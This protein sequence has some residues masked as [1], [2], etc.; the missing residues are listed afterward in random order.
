MQADNEDE[1]LMAIEAIKDRD[2]RAF[3]P[4]IRPSAEEML[5]VDLFARVK[6]CNCLKSLCLKKY[7]E[8]FHNKF[9]CDRRVCRCVGCHN[10]PEK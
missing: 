10:L 7:C 9:A 6:G 5:D 1:L 2:M 8:C 4:R 3:L